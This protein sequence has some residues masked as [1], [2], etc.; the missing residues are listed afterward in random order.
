M[1]NPLVSIIIPYYNSKNVILDTLE[2]IINQDYDNFEIIL[3]NDGSTDNTEKII[4]EKFGLKSI[5]IKNSGPAHARNVGIKASKGKYIAFC[6]ADDHWYSNKISAQVVLLEKNKMA[7]LCFTDIEIIS[8]HKVTSK[9]IKER[10]IVYEGYVF[11]KLLLTNWITTSS[12]MID[13]SFLFNNRLL[14]SEDDNILNVED[15]NYWKIISHYTNFI[16]LDKVTVSR[17]IYQ[18]SFGN[19]NADRQ[20]GRIF[21]SIDNVLTQFK[22]D[23][24]YRKEMLH[25]KTK[26]I[27]FDRIYDDLL[28]GHKEAAQKKIVILSKYSKRK[29]IIIFFKILIHLPR[30]VIRVFSFLNNRIRKMKIKQKKGI[31]RSLDFKN[32]DI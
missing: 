12:V 29:W 20:F 26:L 1:L 7:K 21:Y 23:D 13:S 14:F 27:G 28:Y 30:I 22:F 6:D 17:F 31:V 9:S 10:Y 15:W 19:Q 8:N 3:I 18:D 24:K 4:Y 2:K 5:T 25:K 32:F 16:F 11:E